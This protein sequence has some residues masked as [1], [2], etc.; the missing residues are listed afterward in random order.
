M[1]SIYVLIFLIIVLAFAIGFTL[2]SQKVDLDNWSKGRTDLKWEYVD[3]TVKVFPSVMEINY[4]ERQNDL[5]NLFVL[6]G[7]S[8][9][10]RTNKERTQGEYSVEVVFGTTWEE[11]AMV[12]FPKDWRRY[13]YLKLDIYNP[14]ENLLHLEFRMG[15]CFDAR[16]FNLGSQ[17][18]KKEIELTKGWN[19]LEFSIGEIGEKINMDSFY[20]SVHLSFFLEQAKQEVFIDNVRLVR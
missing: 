14:Q 9:I 8:K 12:Y 5:Y 15:D 11:L 7:E 20:K 16:T 4:F 13:R 1:R 18:F 17:K 2:K 6:S 19:K 3:S 10:E